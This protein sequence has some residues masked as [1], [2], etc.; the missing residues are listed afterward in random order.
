MQK[1]LGELVDALSIVN[2][3]LWH[4]E[5]RARDKTLPDADRLQASDVVRELNA[6]RNQ[7]IEA[8][9]DLIPS[10]RKFRKHPVYEG[11]PIR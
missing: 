2:L 6:E 7:L 11:E 9:D 5:D 8:I 1:T 10:G 4:L 3:K